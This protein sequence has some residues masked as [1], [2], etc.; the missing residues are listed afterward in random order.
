MLCVPA[1]IGLGKLST[2]QAHATAVFAM[3]PISIVSSIVYSISVKV[4]ITVLLL[5]TLGS[6][7]GGLIGSK[8]LKNVK[9][10]I[11]DYIFV[12]VILFAGI[13]MLF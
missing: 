6:L 5:V 1:L 12:T 10:I 11:I 9:S 3:L 13:R 8:L 4:K 2:K 7:I